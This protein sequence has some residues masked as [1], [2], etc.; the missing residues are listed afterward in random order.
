MERLVRQAELVRLP[1]TSYFSGPDLSLRFFLRVL[2]I[3]KEIEKEPRRD[4]NVDIDRR[5]EH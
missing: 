5:V 4:S 1:L 2:M 3:T